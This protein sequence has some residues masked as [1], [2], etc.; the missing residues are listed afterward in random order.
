LVQNTITVGAD[1]KMG[2]GEMDDGSST[3]LIDG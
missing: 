1:K 2:L 3:D